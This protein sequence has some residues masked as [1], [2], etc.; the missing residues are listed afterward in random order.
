MLWTSSLKAYCR[1]IEAGRVLEA[2]ANA[3]LAA[4]AMIASSIGCLQAVGHECEFVGHEREQGG[5]PVCNASEQ[6]NAL[7]ASRGDYVCKLL[8]VPSERASCPR[9]L[10]WW[11]GEMGRDG[12]GQHGD[13]PQVLSRIP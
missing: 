7:F 3:S 12:S 5:S 1:G 4:F 2:I 11:A 9:G 6:S 8:Q 10:P 13:G